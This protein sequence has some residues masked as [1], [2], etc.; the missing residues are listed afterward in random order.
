M[1]NNILTDCNAII[2]AAGKGTRMKSEL[3]KVL[4]KVAGKPLVSHVIEACRAAGVEKP[5]LVVG[6]GSQQ[7]R[8]AIG[9][10]VA[11]CEQ[12]QQL[13]TGHAVM[14]ALPCIDLKKGETFVMCGDAPLIEGETLRELH[15]YFKASGAVC[16]V[17]SA[18]LSDP[19]GYGRIF[20]DGTGR[21]LGI[22]EEKDATENQKK[23]TEINTG[24][25]CFDLAALRSVINEL[26]THN[27]Q[28][29]YYLT[30]VLELL[31]IKGCTVNAM[32]CRDNTAALGVNDRIQQA[33]AEKILRER[34][35][36]RAMRE[37]A[38]IIDPASTYIEAGV[39][40]GADSV[41]RPNT[42]LRG[43]TH[44]GSDCVIGP[45]CEIADSIIGD[46]ST[47]RYAV[48]DHAECGAKANIGPYTYL[49]P[50]TRLA[51]GVK[52]GGFCEVKNSQVGKG[53][54]IP[55][56]SYI[57]D[58]DIGSGVNIGCGSITCNYDGYDKFRTQI[59]DNVFVGSNVSMV[60]PVH[61]APNSFI[62]AGSTVTQDVPEDA[63][64]VARS[65]QSNIEGWAI[66]N[67]EKHQK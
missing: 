12:Y 38:T 35:L 45:D 20:R 3:P 64:A 59:G 10:D 5:L 36:R 58:T 18:T 42:H 24:T 32:K 2:L 15:D 61:I 67:R 34:T 26:D 43:E 44:I 23:I 29:E 31:I 13:G 57:G 6:H 16:T 40:I 60:A 54:K 9:D 25:Y 65:R 21:V 50:G 39:T 28:G 22:I 27:A 14:C 17:L 33:Q 55:H 49:R 19:T 52:V 30:Q 4:H 11:Y 51:E 41:I 48:L 63:L 46:G 56:L 7:V 66:K 37:G 53:S 47:V 62:A 1:Q 8:D